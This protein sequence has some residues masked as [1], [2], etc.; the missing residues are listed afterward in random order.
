[1]AV[2]LCK[3][4][5][6]A[7]QHFRLIRFA[8][9]DDDGI[10]RERKSEKLKIN[11]FFFSF[12]QLGLHMNWACSSV[13][14][15]KLSHI[16]YHTSTNTKRQLNVK[17]KHAKQTDERNHMLPPAP[18]ESADSHCFFFSMWSLS[19][20]HRFKESLGLFF[21]LQ[22]VYAF[23]I[24][25]RK[26]NKMKWKPP[27]IAQTTWNLRECTSKR[28]QRQRQHYLNLNRNYSN[29]VLFLLFLSVWSIWWNEM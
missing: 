24:S 15:W 1:M 18:I 14:R 4:P 8:R 5:N 28:Q 7:S 25:L 29:A 16:K 26:T 2:R 3:T 19:V 9:I 13:N 10:E 20:R 17:K 27:S 23:T 6:D 22:I 21:R 12:I 11:S